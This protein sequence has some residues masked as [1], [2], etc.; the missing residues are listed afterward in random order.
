MEL[1][2]IV[3][4]GWLYKES[5]FLKKWRKYI[6]S[7]I[8]RWV[9]ITRTSVKTYDTQ[10]MQ[11]TPTEEIPMSLCRGVK[12]AEDYTKKQYSFL[13]DIGHTKFYFHAE[14]SNQKEKWIGTLSNQKI[15]LR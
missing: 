4:Q 2:D 12:S 11:K 13:L 10:D 6:F 7:Y 8:R 9:V 15:T 3:H 14:N 1:K 5:R